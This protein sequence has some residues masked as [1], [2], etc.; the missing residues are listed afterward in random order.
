MYRLIIISLAKSLT[1][2]NTCKKVEQV[3]WAFASKDYFGNCSPHLY[4]STI[5]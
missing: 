5:F 3:K 2:G 1:D 4:K